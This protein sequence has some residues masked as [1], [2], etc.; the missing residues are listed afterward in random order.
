MDDF[1]VT[2]KLPIQVFCYTFPLKLSGIV[3]SVHFFP[4]IIFFLKRI[5]RMRQ[6]IKSALGED[7][8]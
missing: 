3:E 2:V 5:R 4:R 8:Q 1:K 7:A 6:I